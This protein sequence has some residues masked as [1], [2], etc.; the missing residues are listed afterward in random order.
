MQEKQ[1]RTVI[2]IKIKKRGTLSK[3][4]LIKIIFLGLVLP[5]SVMSLFEETTDK[6]V[7]GLME[8]TRRVITNNEQRLDRNIRAVMGQ[9]D[10]PSLVAAIIQ[11][12][13]LVWAKGYGEQPA[14]DTIYM[15]GSIT[16]TFTATAML[17][18][19]EQGLID[20]DDDVSSYLPFELRNPS[21]P[22]VPITIRMLLTHQSSLNSSQ[23]I[24]GYYQ[25][26]F[27]DLFRNISQF[28]EIYP[29]YPLWL[30]HYLTSNGSL[31]SPNLWGSWEPGT[32][33]VYSNTGYTIL[34]YLVE[35]VSNKTF[36]QYLSDHI[37]SPL[38][39]TNIGYNY[40][41]FD[42]EKLAIPYDQHLVELWPFLFGTN[43]SEKV[44]VLPSYNTE[45]T[46]DGGL[47]TSVL[48]LSH[49]FI[50]HMNGGV[51]NGVR[52]L[53]EKTIELMHKKVSSYYGLGWMW[54]DYFQTQGHTGAM[55]GFLSAMVFVQSGADSSVPYGIIFFINKRW[56]LN[57][58]DTCFAA[59]YNQLIRA[60]ESVPFIPS[61]SSS[62]SSSSSSSTVTNSS[63]T[64]SAINS[65]GFMIMTF[66]GSLSLMVTVLLLQ[67][68][69][70]QNI[71]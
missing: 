19:Y 21:Y 38:N 64:S 53:E 65:S 45:A 35:L 26:K 5:L 4:R 30:E 34:S 32:E 67:K 71:G 25:L 56:P 54:N 36:E 17:Q 44:E 15:I 55:F 57:Q 1:L 37:F 63:G 51:Y 16:K 70:K 10:V 50:A 46:G 3:T 7:Q 24:C 12:T 29:P 66:M 9:Y 8:R 31:Y 39:M 69:R 58:T 20:L 2:E 14:N 18:L 48:D 60:A 61:S 22:D 40:S 43:M 42:S 33:F 68:R 47:R 41:D 59:V 62:T 23:E 6:E 27:Q 49:F 13:S 28:N 11:N 52:I